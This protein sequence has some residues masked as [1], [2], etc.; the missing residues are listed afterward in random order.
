MRRI[1]HKVADTVFMS[2]AAIGSVCMI[3]SA[4]GSG[5]SFPLLF[6]LAALGVIGCILN[7]SPDASTE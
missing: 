3:G 4:F 5:K 7:D 6:S 1:F 2:A